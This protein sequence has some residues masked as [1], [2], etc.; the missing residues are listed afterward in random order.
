MLKKIGSPINYCVNM[1]RRIKTNY[2]KL[3]KDSM[4][5]NKSFLVYAMYIHKHVY[6]C[7]LFKTLNK[8]LNLQSIP[9]RT[10]ILLSLSWENHVTWKTEIP[11]IA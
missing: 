2:G 8:T 11:G 10:K 9:T 6:M 5:N 3:N 4:T 7:R 1:L